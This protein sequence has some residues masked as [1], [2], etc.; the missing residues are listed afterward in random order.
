MKLIPTSFAAFAIASLTAGSLSAA[1]V[2]QEDFTGSAGNL[3][4]RDVSPTPQFVDNDWW[5]QTGSSKQTGTQME[6]DGSTGTFA[7]AGVGFDDSLLATNTQTITYSVDFSTTASYADTDSNIYFGV[8]N[9][10]GD[11]GTAGHYTSASDDGSGKYRNST[12]AFGF[13]MSGNFTSGSN[14]VSLRAGTDGNPTGFTVRDDFDRT[15]TI[16][17]STFSMTYTLATDTVV[18]YIDGNDIGSDTYT[19]DIGG[20]WWKAD[21]MR[22]KIDDTNYGDDGFLFDNLMITTTVP[23][24]GTYAL[25]AGMLG[26]T[27]VMLRRRK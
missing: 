27:S 16:W 15:D 22:Y 5:A 23:E 1:T 6:L 21:N 20:L 26:L 13:H 7:K 3:N 19:G 14:A 9:S 8:G 25:I 12:L 4:G 18:Y 11:G 17:S 24:P 10:S 2:F